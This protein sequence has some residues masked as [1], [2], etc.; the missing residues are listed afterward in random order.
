MAE[1]YV[2]VTV[3]VYFPFLRLRHIWY[4]IY[5]H[6]SENANAVLECDVNIMGKDFGLWLIVQR[7]TGSADTSVTKWK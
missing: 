4:N 6:F 3:S 1:Q 5:L 2:L 7:G